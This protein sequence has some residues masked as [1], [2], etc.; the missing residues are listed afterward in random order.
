MKSA[1]SVPASRANTMMLSSSQKRGTLAQ[2]EEDDV[3]TAAAIKP[4]DHAFDLHPLPGGLGAEV[5]RLA[6][7]AVGDATFPAIYEAF[8]AHQ[9]LLFRD[10]DLPPGDQV[11][12][13]RRL[14]KCRFT[15]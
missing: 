15:S 4:T 14:A 1:V 2:S 5:R 9:L 6:A 8:L 13:A 11:A 7:S 3:S 10:H 12:F